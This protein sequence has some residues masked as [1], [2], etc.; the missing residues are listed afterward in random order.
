VLYLTKGNFPTEHNEKEKRN[1]G[2]EIP[3]GTQKN[4][5]QCGKC[6]LVCP[7]AVIRAKIYDPQCLK[8]AAHQLQ[9]CRTQMERIQT[10]RYTLQV[11]P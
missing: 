4:V 7:H 1:I 8:R 6:V 3:V 5:Y 9:N 10:N 2:L 11:S